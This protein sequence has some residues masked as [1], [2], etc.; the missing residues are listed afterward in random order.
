MSGPGETV[1]D[2]ARRRRWLNLAELVAVAGVLIA[3]AGLYLS[4]SD[5]RDR[6][7]AD[8]QAAQVTGRFEIRATPRDD[9]AALMLRHD[10]RHDVASM[11]VTFPAA[12][13]V[14]RREALAERIERDWFARP[15]LKATDG[16]PDD[17]TGT[18]PVLIRVRYTDGDVMRT[19][20]GIYDVVWRTAGRTFPLGRSLRLEALRLRERGGSTARLDALW[21]PAGRQTARA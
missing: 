17:Q 12:L 13:G 21:R 18:L 15:L 1:E 11:D 19:A 6:A 20:S 3:A 4:W 5:R 8:A 16:G 14:G 10:E 2:R 9:G 7:T